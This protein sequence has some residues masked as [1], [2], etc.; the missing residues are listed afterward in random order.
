MN[1]KEILEF[2]EDSAEKEKAIEDLTKQKIAEFMDYQKEVLE[3]IQSMIKDFFPTEIKKMISQYINDKKRIMVVSDLLWIDVPNNYTRIQLN[4]N[5]FCGCSVFEGTLSHLPYNPKNILELKHNFKCL[6]NYVFLKNE[7][8]NGIEQVYDLLCE[9][10]EEK[11]NRELDFLN[12]L[13][14]SAP[15]KKERYKVTIIIEKVNQQNELDA[16]E[17]F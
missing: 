11:L 3:N 6:Q 7:L 12:S 14:F 16:N 4:P 8:E 10:K 9:W 2:I 13:P 15:A 5:R 1:K 17:K